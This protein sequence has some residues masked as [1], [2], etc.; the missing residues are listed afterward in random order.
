MKKLM[1]IL[2]VA[3]LMTSLFACS[4]KEETPV[5]PLADYDKF[6]YETLEIYIPKK[7]LAQE[8][9]LDDFE[10][11]LDSSSMAVFI[12]SLAKSDLANTNYTLDEL[13][14]MVF[15]GQDVKYVNDIP[16]FTYT[17]LGTDNVEY[18]YVYAMLEDADRVWDFHQACRADE[19]EEYR[20]IMLDVISKVV[21][22]Q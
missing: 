2:L 13:K 21:V 19:A 5:D 20:D 16:Y 6:T 11:A 17:N 4:K 10:Y 7:V 1:H 8:T 15:E 9:T 22:H 3:L 14:A 12:K 18:F